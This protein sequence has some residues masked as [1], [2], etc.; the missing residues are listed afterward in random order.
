[1]LPPFGVRRCPYTSQGAPFQRRA[2]WGSLGIFGRA[3]THPPSK[4]AFSGLIPSAAR[5]LRSDLGEIPASAASFL[6]SLAGNGPAPS[7]S[8]RNSVASAFEDFESPLLSPKAAS[9]SLAVNVIGALSYM[10]RDVDAGTSM[11]D[12]APLDPVRY[13]VA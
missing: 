4:P 1:M 6:T 13:T 8:N 11:L 12:H 7:T 9:A 3:Q 10:M 2:S 5:A